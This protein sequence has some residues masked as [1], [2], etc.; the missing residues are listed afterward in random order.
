MYL[1]EQEGREDTGRL[2][3]MK[4]HAQIILYAEIFQ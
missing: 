4:E 1:G 3:E 2:E